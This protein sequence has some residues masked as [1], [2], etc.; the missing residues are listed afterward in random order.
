MNT[1]LLTATI[2]PPPGVP[3]LRRTDPSERLRDYAE[4]LSFYCA[5][6]ADVIH[7]IVFIEN[8]ATD[9]TP[10]RDVAAKAEASQ[11]V[12]FVSFN[13]LDHPAAY[14]R[15]Y[16]EF[17]LLDYAMQHSPSL[18]AA[19]E[20]ERLW[21]AT[22]RYRI[23]N[24]VDLIRTAPKT[25]DLY[26]DLRDRP[27]PWM[28]LRVF[29]ATVGGYRRLLMGIYE[30][31]REDVIH[32]SPERYLRPVIGELAKSHQIVTRFC[33]EPRI[34]GIRGMDSRNYTSGVNLLKYW[35]RATTRRLQGLVNPPA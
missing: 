16:G 17:K 33:R 29:A 32:V 35:Y 13:G 15:G 12:E 19:N 8:S 2:T 7:R 4:A 9:V 22:G 25:F 30:Q 5:L 1:L 3:G 24:L 27:I 26:C 18:V 10:L 11:R 34:D 28:D 23:L 31:L 6:P 14:G 21:K 20:D